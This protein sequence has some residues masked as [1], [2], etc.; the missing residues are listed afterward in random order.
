MPAVYRE[1]EH[2]IFIIGFLRISAPPSSVFSRLRRFGEDILI[3]N[4]STV[5]ET[6]LN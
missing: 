6:E 5:S 4:E 3:S 1:R 2:N